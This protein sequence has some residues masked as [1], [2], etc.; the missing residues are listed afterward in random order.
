MQFYSWGHP[1]KS[2]V[3]LIGASFVVDSFISF[4]ASFG[5]DLVFHILVEIIS[6]LVTPL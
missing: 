6:Y 3:R 1:E 4:G 5:V 2:G